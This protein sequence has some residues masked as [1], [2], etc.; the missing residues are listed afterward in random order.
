M[1]SRRASIAPQPVAAHLTHPLPVPSSFPPSRPAP[2]RPEY[3]DI[4]SA[5]DEDELPP[6]WAFTKNQQPSE[7]R[8]VRIRAPSPPPPADLPDETDRTVRFANSPPPQPSIP[9]RQRVGAARGRPRAT[10]YQRPP[11][12]QERG[13]PSP[14][15]R[16]VVTREEEP[17]SAEEEQEVILV[18]D[19][20]PP[21]HGDDSS[22]D[23]VLELFVKP[24]ELGF[25]GPFKK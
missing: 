23:E 5:S 13:Q 19:D 3:E 24:S 7:S 4:S 8:T 17:E 6:I 12:P 1:G 21:D 16:V 15:A 25:L 11:P 2:R 22:E 14:P 10:P 9:A 20:A 18:D